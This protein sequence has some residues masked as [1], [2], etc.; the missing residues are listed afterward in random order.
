MWYTTDTGQV[1]FKHQDDVFKINRH[2]FAVQVLDHP[3]NIP[4]KRVGEGIQFH[5]GKYIFGNSRIK[6]N[7]TQDL[8]LYLVGCRCEVKWLLIHVLRPPLVA[9]A[10]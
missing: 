8:G 5:L 1:F 9:F 4:V 2:P 6:E 10:V 7:R 3:V